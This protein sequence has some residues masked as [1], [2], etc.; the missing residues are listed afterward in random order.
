M[1]TLLKHTVAPSGGDYTTLKDAYA[2]LVAAHA[3]LVTADVYAEIEISGNWSGSPDTTAV[4]CNGLT[5]DATHYV[6]IYTD[7]SNRA[8]ATWD[9][10]KYILS[11]SNAS[12]LSILDDYVRIDGMQITTP[13]IDGTDDA[14]LQVAGITA[15]NNDIRISNCTLKGANDPD[16]RQYVFSCSDAD[17]ILTMWN[18]YAYDA[19]PAVANAAGFYLNPATAN[20]YNCLAYNC[21]KGL[22]RAAGTVNVYDSVSFYNADDFSGTFNVIDYCASDDGDGTNAVA[23]SGGGAAWPSDFN[24]A[25]SGNFTLVSTSNLIGAGGRAGSGTFSTDIAGTTRGAAWDLGPF[26]YV[27]SAVTPR[28]RM[29]I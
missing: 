17:T 3:N 27:S 1:A 15:T 4:S 5:T 21:Q 8:G 19:S 16:T 11:V 10:T 20:L 25:A 2:H 6:H 13:A 12:A 14:V 18:C 9:T 7:S 23:E 28:I 29:I 26:E 24:A 22:T